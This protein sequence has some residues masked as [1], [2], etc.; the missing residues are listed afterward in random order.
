MADKLLDDAQ[1]E[2]ECGGDRSAAYNTILF[3]QY[4]GDPQIN[5]RVASGKRLCLRPMRGGNA[6]IEQTGFSKD[7]AAG[8]IR[9]QQ[10]AALML[11]AE[12]DAEGLQDIGS[13]EKA[14]DIGDEWTRHDHGIRGR[15]CVDRTI[16]GHDLT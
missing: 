10:G 11:T 14:F 15:S 6:A 3:G 4:L 7:E 16:H 12:R 8:A 1:R 2:I 13:C 9:G 5:L